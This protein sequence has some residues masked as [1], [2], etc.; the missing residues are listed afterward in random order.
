VLSRYFEF[1]KIATSS[2]ECHLAPGQ[3]PGLGSQEDL[4]RIIGK[5]KS[6]PE[7]NKAELLEK[8]FTDRPARGDQERALNIAARVAMMINCSASRQFSVLLEH[9]NQQT[10]WHNDVTFSQFLCGIFPQNA[11]PSIEDIKESLQ[12]T[13]LKKRARLS[14]QPTDDLKNHLRLDRKAAVVEIFHHTAFL[15]EQLRLTKDQPRNLY[16]PDLIKMYVRKKPQTDE[17]EVTSSSYS[18]VRKIMQTMLTLGIPSGALPRALAIEALDSIQ[19]VLFPLTDPK[20]KELLLSLTS[21]STG[22]FDTDILRY[23]SVSIRKPDEHTAQ[24]HYFGARLG[25]L[26]HEL[27]NPTPR[28]FEKWFERN[29]GARSVMMA[30][31]SG[32]VFAILLGL[33]GLGLGGFQ[34]YTGYMAW[35]HPV[36]PPSKL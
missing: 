20:S 8:L 23:D 29:S 13:K 34:A 4:F 6:K 14:F 28:G 1:F 26:H 15:K 16:V 35:K 36:Q 22:N 21:T 9:G 31:I 32:V 2:Y 7:L 27:M 3:A 11:H 5:L 24:Y 19:K 30:T 18:Q 10:R 33:L 17:E 12:A 25:D